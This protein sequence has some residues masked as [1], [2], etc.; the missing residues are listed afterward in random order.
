MDIFHFVMTGEKDSEQIK[1]SMKQWIILIYVTKKY[2]NMFRSKGGHATLQKLNNI[3]VKSDR[4][5]DEHYLKARRIASACQ[6]IINYFRR[7]QA[8]CVERS[9][10][11]CACLRTLQFPSQVVIGIRSAVNVISHYQSHAWVEMNHM[12]INDTI[13][14]KS[15][16]IE[17]DRVPE[18]EVVH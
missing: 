2:L 7:D 3:E 11:I 15:H 5:L 1:L 18:E 14:V 10:A 4:L 6:M 9:I 12:P 8:M 17:L 16:F 13:A